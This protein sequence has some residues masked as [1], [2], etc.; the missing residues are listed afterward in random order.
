MVDRREHLQEMG[1]Q[2]PGISACPAHAE[3]AYFPFEVDLPV[4][5]YSVVGGEHLVQVIV[6]RV[7]FARGFSE[8]AR[9]PG[10]CH[11]A[12]FTLLLSH[13]AGAGSPRPA[14]CHIRWCRAASV[15]E[16]AFTVVPEEVECAFA[17]ALT[18]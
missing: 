11:V 17:Y 10:A 7:I 16:C 1:L 4:R 12:S 8:A 14:A 18:R 13:H 15:S 2:L 6:D 9:A 3:K 5:A